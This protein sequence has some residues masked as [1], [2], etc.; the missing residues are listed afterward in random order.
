MLVVLCNKILGGRATISVDLLSVDAEP[1]L[2][3]GT[4]VEKK[5]SIHGAPV[6]LSS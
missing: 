4:E 6:S 3:K 2:P 5:A 1:A